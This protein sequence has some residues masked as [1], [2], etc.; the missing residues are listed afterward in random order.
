MDTIIVKENG[1]IFSNGFVFRQSFGFL[2][3]FFNYFTFCQAV[4]L[5]NLY[6]AVW[7]LITVEIP[8]GPYS[9]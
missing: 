3:L 1:V 7:I 2:F 8:A 6:C 9:F 5:Y 4:S